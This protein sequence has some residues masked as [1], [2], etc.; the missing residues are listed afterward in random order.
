MHTKLDTGSGVIVYDLLQNEFMV[1]KLQQSALK[2]VP[3]SVKNKLSIPRIRC[4]KRAE[5]KNVLMY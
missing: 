5:V 1:A 2:K 4:I 3:F